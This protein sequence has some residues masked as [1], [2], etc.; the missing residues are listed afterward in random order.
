VAQF[1]SDAFLL[2]ELV[3]RDFQSRYTGSLLG[4]AWAFVQ[5]LALLALFTMV[6]SVVLKVRFDA[7]GAHGHFASF[8][9]CGLLPWMAFNEGTLRSTTAITDNATLVRKLRFPAELLILAAV[10]VALLHEAIAALVFGGVLAVSGQ[11]VW[12]GLPW[13]LLALPLQLMLSVGFGLLLSPIHVFFRDLAQLLG[14]ALMAWFYFTPIVY[15][16]SMVP[17]GLRRWIELNPMTTLVEIYRQALLGG[18]HGW[19][20]GTT[21]LA[22]ISAVLLFA[23]FALF[24]RLRSTFADEL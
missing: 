24:R 7:M 15:P 14:L 10:L 5:P 23:G 19:V 3:K 8:L 21:A 4:F 20:P 13:L 12:Q 11:L 22:A 1:R 6:F 9:F 17:P 16:L 2:K 18:S